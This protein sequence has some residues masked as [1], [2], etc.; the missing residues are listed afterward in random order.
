MARVRWRASDAP[1]LDRTRDAS[2][3]PALRAHGIH[4]PTRMARW[5]PLHSFETGEAMPDDLT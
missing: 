1:I 4:A 2:D 3:V 5:L